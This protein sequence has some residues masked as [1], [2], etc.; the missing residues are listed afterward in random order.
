LKTEIELRKDE[1]DLFARWV[2]KH[3]GLT[4]IVSTSNKYKHQ[5]EIKNPSPTDVKKM[6][7]HINS[8]IH[9]REKNG[10]NRY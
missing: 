8:I 7:E 6:Q 9:Y 1:A 3:F 10:Y 4:A 2:K 5:V